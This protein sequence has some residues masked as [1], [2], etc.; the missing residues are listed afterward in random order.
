MLSR[1]SFVLGLAGMSVCL[2]GCTK[3]DGRK[4]VFPVSGKVLDG[5]RPL[6]HASV[7][8]HPVNDTDANVVKPRGKTDANGEFKL[9][10]YVEGD[11][12]PVGSYRVTIEL[13]ATVNADQGPVNRVLPKYGK[14]ESSGFTA[15]VTAGPTTLAPFELK[16]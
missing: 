8:F 14:A 4:P 13:W 5:T 3:S 11:G 10:T 16:R 6:A 12:A 15:E 7:V 9:T 1:R 2:G